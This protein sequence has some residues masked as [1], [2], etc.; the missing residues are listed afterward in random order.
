MINKIFNVEDYIRSSVAAKMQFDEQYSPSMVV[1]GNL[2]LLH[3]RIILPL[4]EVLKGDLIISSG[5]RCPRLN[6]Q[7]GGVIDSQHLFGQAV[8]FKL[9]FKWSKN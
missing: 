9:L 6:K 5:Y 4:L 3:T 2:R 1:L 8:R 7:V